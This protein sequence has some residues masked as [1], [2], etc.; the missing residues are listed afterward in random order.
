MQTPSPAA[1][2]ATCNSN[3]NPSRTQLCW[4]NT[5]QTHR[6][7]TH[8]FMQSENV[9]HHFQIFQHTQ[10]RTTHKQIH[11][12]LRHTAE[13]IRILR[14][15]HTYSI[16]AQPHQQH[17]ATSSRFYN[18]WE[19]AT[20]ASAS[21]ASPCANALSVGANS[22]NTLNTQTSARTCAPFS[23]PTTFFYTIFML[24][25][26][27]LS[28]PNCF[29]GFCACFC[30]SFFFIVGAFGMRCKMECINDF[31]YEDAMTSL[32][33]MWR[34]WCWWWNDIIV[35]SRQRCVERYE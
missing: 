1:M 5:R 26:V 15:Q 11:P 28:S 25:C 9:S 35:V 3:K 24:P 10:A 16:V 30:F 17:S 7:N 13:I 31:V 29:G 18:K 8:I 19:E 12:Q 33:T 32:K 27:H 22:A 2:H 21:F 4:A 6:H 34:R 23:L 20:S 14:R